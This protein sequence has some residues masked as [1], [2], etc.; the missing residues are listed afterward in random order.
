VGGRFGSGSGQR[1]GHMPV[2]KEVD[3]VCRMEEFAMR[4]VFSTT[5]ILGY[6]NGQDDILP[7]FGA[8]PNDLVRSSIPTWCGHH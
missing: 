7:T 5:L 1:E 3:I 6:T 4:Y 2:I 8:G